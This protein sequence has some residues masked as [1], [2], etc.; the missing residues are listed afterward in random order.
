MA[1]RTFS[2]LEASPPNVLGYFQGTPGT[3]GTL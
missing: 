3:P 2:R 1:D